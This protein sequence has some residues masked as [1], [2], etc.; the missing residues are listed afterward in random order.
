LGHE[1]RMTSG[2]RKGLFHAPMP[3]RADFSS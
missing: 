1:R 2:A 3:L